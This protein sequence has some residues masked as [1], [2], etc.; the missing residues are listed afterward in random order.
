MFHTGW[1]TQILSGNKLR[2]ILDNKVQLAIFLFLL[3]VPKTVGLLRGI[4]KEYGFLVLIC[5]SF[6]KKEVIYLA[7]DFKSLSTH[8]Y[9]VLSFLPSLSFSHCCTFFSKP[10]HRSPHSNLPRGKLTGTDPLE[11][12]KEKVWISSRCLKR[13]I[14]ITQGWRIKGPNLLVIL[15]NAPHSVN[16]TFNSTVM[17]NKA[18]ICPPCIWDIICCFFKPSY[19]LDVVE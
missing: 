10:A 18:D 15:N 2:T 4:K 3:I 13:V 16:S 14:Y 17:S 6:P 5:P 12:K 19:T 9:L 8:L 11:H 7:G 1:Q